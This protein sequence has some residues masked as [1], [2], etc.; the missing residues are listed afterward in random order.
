MAARADT[1]ADPPFV[2][3]SWSNLRRGP[4]P[5]ERFWLEHPKNRKFTIEVWNNSEE[6]ISVYTN[7]V[8]NEKDFRPLQRA[9]DGMPGTVNIAPGE[10]GKM[11]VEKTR[12]LSAV[13]LHVCLLDGRQIPLSGQGIYILI[14]AS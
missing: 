10:K 8:Q 14:R 5:E 3:G 6:T 9:A 11:P 4:T 2:G 12:N 13:G 7:G 1:L